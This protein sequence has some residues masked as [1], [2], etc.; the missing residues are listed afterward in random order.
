MIEKTVL[1]YLISKNLSAG[2]GVYMEVPLNPPD[3][4]IVIEKTGSS[5]YNR[6]NQAMLAIK[7]YSKKSLEEAA[8]LNEEVLEAMDAITELT[9]IFR[10]ELNSDYNYTNYETKEY[11]YQAVYNLYY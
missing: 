11:R 3:K 6:I 8:M 9:E 4:Y 10:A 5:R 7:S 2:T 1:D